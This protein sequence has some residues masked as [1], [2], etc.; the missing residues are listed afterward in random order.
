[1]SHSPAQ[2][3]LRM[4]ALIQL[5]EIRKAHTQT[6]GE[7]LADIIESGKKAGTSPTDVC[8]EVFGETQT[9][10]EL[11]KILSNFYVREVE[12]LVKLGVCESVPVS[13]AEEASIEAAE[14]LTRAKGH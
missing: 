1:M 13:S 11:R 10:A 7:D 6:L 12:L 5:L 2:T 14:I 3:T 4:I 8:E 9:A